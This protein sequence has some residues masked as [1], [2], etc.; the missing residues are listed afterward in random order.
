M[1]QPVIQRLS[2]QLSTMPKYVLA[3]MGGGLI[4]L[5][6]GGGGYVYHLETA[7]PHQAT[8]SAAVDSPSPSPTDSPSP[9]PIDSP[10]PTPID[11]PSPVSTPT[12]APVAS[13][14]AQAAPAPT[15]APA[16]ATAAPASTPPPPAAP[17]PPPAPSFESATAT[18]GTN[19]DPAGTTL[20][21][22]WSVVVQ[23]TGPFTVEW[24]INGQTSG[25]TGPSFTANYPPGTYHLTQVRITDANGISSVASGG[26]ASAVV[27]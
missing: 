18:V 3:G 12:A 20:P 5:A 10:S 7:A 19:S 9:T 6:A 24:T 21:I 26:L 25:P 2:K 22:T 17:T 14:V 23:G 1:M 11:S 16:P 15:S 27:A 8:L 4:V 13:P